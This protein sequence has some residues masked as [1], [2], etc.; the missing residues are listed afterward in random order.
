MMR[1][2]FVLLILV[3]F[4]LISLAAEKPVWV[5]AEGEA[6]QGEFDTLKEI[7]GRARRDAQN[8]AVEMAVGTFIKS[9]TLV[10]NS[11]VAEDL[12][13]AAVRGKITKEKILFSDWDA[14]ERNLYK[15]RI[16]ALV[17]PVYPEK[18][19]G[20]SVRLSLSKSDLR[21]GD[22]VKIFYTVSEDAYV[23]IFSVA[24]DGSVTLLLPNA[25]LA[26]NFVRANQAGQFPPAGNPISLKAMFLPG[27]EGKTAEERIK[28]IATK[29]KE[30]LLSLGFQE[31]L[32]QVYNEKSTGMIGDLV[33][34][35][36]AI[37]PSDWA[38]AVAVYQLKK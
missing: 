2:L 33:R 15:I 4:P 37:D 34:R 12:I 38:Q 30:P 23:Y 27:Y 10:S 35:L 19:E 8:K 32:F 25:H 9:H 22:E 14:Q 26:D 1:K 17:E 16:K 31:G 3:I 7:K 18:G 28:I 11:Q 29:K 36:N 5:T 13:Y 6:L 24:A 21:E 20:L